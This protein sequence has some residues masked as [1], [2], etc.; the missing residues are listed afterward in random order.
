MFFGMPAAE[1]AFDLV[2]IEDLLGLRSRNL[3][4]QLAAAPNWAKRFALLDNEL[5]RRMANEPTRSQS[6]VETGQAWDLLTR[7]KGNLRISDLA[8]QVGISRRYLSAIFD[9]EFGITPKLAGRILRFEHATQLA[10]STAP[11]PWAG[12][13]AQAGFSDQA[14]LTREWMEF[15]RCSP[16]AWRR[17]EVKDS[18][19]DVA[20]PHQE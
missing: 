12:I 6:R 17:I 4:D 14:H 20:S 1:L 7:S 19:V 11:I 9:R 2:S 16:S 3:C 8:E 15:C 5:L 13:A 18:V 10:R